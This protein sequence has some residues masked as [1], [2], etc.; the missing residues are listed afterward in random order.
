MPIVRIELQKGKDDAY[1][2][3]AGEVVYEAM[4]SATG[5]PRND[6]FQIISEHSAENFIYDETYLG[7]RRTSDLIMIQ[8]FFNEGRTVEQ[9]RTLYKTIADSLSN[10]LKLRPEDVFINLI[11]AKP[12]NWSFGLGI[13]QY[14]P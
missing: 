11:E 5:V 13:A 8:I 14:A 10:R 1:R 9:K 12:E 4:V 2:R 3:V 6:H 7:I